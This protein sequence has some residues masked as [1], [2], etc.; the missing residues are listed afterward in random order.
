MTDRFKRPKA[1]VEEAAQLLF[2]ARL[3]AI[4]A[5]FE[6]AT[7]LEVMMVCTWALAQVAGGLC[8]EHLAEFE[9][10]LLA[11]LREC[12]AQDREAEDAAAAEDDTPPV[13]H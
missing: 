6:G 13:R 12:V 10:D 8:D 2:L 9:A 1:K 7:A 11:H 4:D 5:I 3:E